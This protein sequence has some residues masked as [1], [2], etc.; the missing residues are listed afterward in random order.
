VQDQ[1][2]TQ[3][4]P[5]QGKCVHGR[6]PIICIMF[7]STWWVCCG[8]FA[9]AGK[10]VYGLHKARGA[11]ARAAG[12]RGGARRGAERGPG[13]NRGGE[14]AAPRGGRTPPRPRQRGRS[15]GAVRESSSGRPRGPPW[16]I[17]RGGPRAAPARGRRRPL[18]WARALARPR[19]GRPPG[20]RRGHGPR[21]GGH[22]GGGASTPPRRRAG[23]T[24]LRQL[25]GAFRLHP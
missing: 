22:P 11:R 8:L 10:M 25:S 21:P 16:R 7:G 15:C 20:F 24:R 1:C 4:A 14:A 12:T 23:P 13:G 6:G 2:S 5:W 19:H 9:G 18:P 3:D 17:G